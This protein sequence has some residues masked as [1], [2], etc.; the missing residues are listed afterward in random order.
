MN[1][2]QLGAEVWRSWREKERESLSQVPQL[3]PLPA[4]SPL[5][6]QTR[7]ALLRVLQEDEEHWGST[8]DWTSSLA[9][10]VCEVGGGEEQ[11]ESAGQC[12]VGKWDLP[13]PLL[14]PSHPP[15]PCSCWKSTQSERPASARSSG[16]GWLT[17]AWGGWQSSC[18]GTEGWGQVRLEGG[19][20][21]RSGPGVQ[22]REER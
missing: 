20:G 9:Q 15:G 11:G 12:R 8:E 21:R 14:I 17:A 16:S 1:P 18:R 7:A 22:Q 3:L 2:D 5:Q 6:A 19:A 4:T 13:R 10:D